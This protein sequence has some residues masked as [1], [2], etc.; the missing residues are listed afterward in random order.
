MFHELATLEMVIPQKEVNEDEL[1]EQLK[2]TRLKIT[3]LNLNQEMSGTVSEELL[4]VSS[5]N[6]Y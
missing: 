1:I 5:I 3:T 6:G 2:R 4:Q